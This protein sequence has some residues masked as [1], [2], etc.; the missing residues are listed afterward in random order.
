MK[1]ERSIIETEILPGSQAFYENELRNGSEST[2][3]MY[4]LLS[5]HLI[6]SDMNIVDILI[7][8]ENLIHAYESVRIEAS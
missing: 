3:R 2:D 8:L 4:Y 6:N 5:K 1:K 7:C